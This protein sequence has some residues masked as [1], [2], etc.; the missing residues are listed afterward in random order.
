MAKKLGQ[1]TEICTFP[2]ANTRNHQKQKE[3]RNECEHHRFRV[4]HPRNS[5]EQ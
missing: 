3:F 4:L 5:S 1:P 2:L